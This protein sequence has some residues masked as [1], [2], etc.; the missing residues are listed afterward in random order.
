MDLEERKMKRV[1][2]GLIVAWV[3]FLVITDVYAVPP[4]N[5][6]GNLLTNGNFET[7]VYAPW[8]PLEGAA[9]TVSTEYQGDGDFSA[10]CAFGGGEGGVGI[11]QYPITPSSGY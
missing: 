2:L 1:M 9:V 3:C 7:G 5:Q 6:T 10:F 8:A 11:Y 4:L